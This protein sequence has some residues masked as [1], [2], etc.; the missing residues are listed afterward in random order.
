MCGFS[1]VTS[2]LLFSAT[3][4]LAASAVA[5]T[6]LAGLADFCT[7][8]VT[9]IPFWSWRGGGPGEGGHSSIGSSVITLWGNSRIR[10]EETRSGLSG[11]ECE[12]PVRSSTVYTLHP[13]HSEAA[14]AERERERIASPRLQIPRQEPDN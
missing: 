8:A 1:S 2:S 9:S 6:V 5:G 12:W 4:R 13:L 3:R 14:V 11:P 7:G 10:E